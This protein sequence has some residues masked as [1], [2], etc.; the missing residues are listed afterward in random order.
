MMNWQGFL[1]AFVCLLTKVLCTLSYEDSIRAILRNQ[2]I[3]NDGSNGTVWFNTTGYGLEDYGFPLIDDYGIYTYTSFEYL[4]H[5][6]GLAREAANRGKHGDVILLLYKFLYAG[7]AKATEPVITSDMFRDM[8]NDLKPLWKNSDR[9]ALLDILEETSSIEE[10]KELYSQVKKEG[11]AFTPENDA[12]LRDPCRNSH[13]A[14]RNA[15]KRLLSA[16]KSDVTWR[17]GGPRNIEYNGCFISWGKD[18][19][20]QVK[21]LQYLT[22]Y[23]YEICDGAKISCKFGSAGNSNVEQGFSKHGNRHSLK[24]E[25][26]KIASNASAFSQKISI[27]DDL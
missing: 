11:K 17:P 25:N 26:S 27:H 12:Q 14:D 5:V 4:R 10:L 22:K 16:M 15:C 2:I 20:L 1:M 3:P 18:S 23:C 8:V 13:Q 24:A 21:D 6:T 9:N 7:Q 19:N